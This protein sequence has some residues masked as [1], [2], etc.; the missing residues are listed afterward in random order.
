M[1]Q[2][3]EIPI[4]V[5]RVNET[6]RSGA[7]TKLILSN[8]KLAGSSGSLLINGSLITLVDF[9][10]VDAVLGTVAAVQEAQFYFKARLSSSFPRELC[11]KP[12]GGLAGYSA[13]LPLFLGIIGYLQPNRLITATGNVKVLR[14]DVWNVEL[15]AVGGVKEKISACISAGFGCLLIGAGSEEEIKLVR[16]SALAYKKV[17]E[18][19]DW[20]VET[21]FEFAAS[22]MT[23]IVVT[24]TEEARD[25]CAWWNVNFSEEKLVTR[26]KRRENDEQDMIN[27]EKKYLK[28]EK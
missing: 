19:H 26:K 17:V 5:V 11:I 15:G 21:S 18:V 22:K 2:Y 27:W 20:R 23:V 10:D 12:V 3:K 9:H 24:T 25:A 7:I 16:E 6:G 1:F 14:T 8:K 13:S 4:V 28:Y